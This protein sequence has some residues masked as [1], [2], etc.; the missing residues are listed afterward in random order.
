M[1]VAGR[2]PDGGWLA[3]QELH[4]WDTC[5]IP[6]AQARFIPGSLDATPVTYPTLPVS[7]W[8]K[9]PNPVAH[10]E[11][12]E[13]KVSWQ[14]VGMDKYDY[15]GYLIIAWVCQAGKLV[16]LP[17]NVMPPFAENTGTLSVTIQDEPGCSAATRAHIYTAEKRGYMG[18]LI[19]W[20]AP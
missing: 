7:Y 13:V 20:P 11:G 3:V 2:S 17:I 1:E 16:Y 8:Y 6:V 5:W 9:P 18:T 15:R 19:I 14:A 4:G 10:R 12:N